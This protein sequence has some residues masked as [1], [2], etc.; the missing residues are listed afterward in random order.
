MPFVQGQLRGE[1]TSVVIR[2]KCA[3]C[4]QPISIGLDSELRYQVME[5]GPD[6]LVF[7]P[8]VNL[9]K[10]TDRCIIDAF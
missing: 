5:G 4:D 2:S 1:P 10:L 8:M 7:L 6:P 9:E 3:H